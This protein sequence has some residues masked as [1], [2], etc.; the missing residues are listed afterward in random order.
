MH[1]ADAIIIGGGVTGLSTAYHLAKRGFGR[2][3]V[4]EKGPVGDGSSSRAGGIIT[5]LL[6]SEAGVLARKK[7]LELYRA[8]SE[9]LDGYT[10]QA[11][12][13]LN[14]FD[15]PSWP[16]RERLLPLYDRLGA[17]YE[18]MSAAEMR[19]RWPALVIRDEDC[20]L[21]DPLG[22]YSEPHEYVPALAR[23]VRELGVEIREQTAVSELIVRGGRA[24]GV[25]TAD[26]VIEAGAVV[27]TVYAWTHVVLGPHGV[28]LPVKSFVHQRYVTVPLAAPV[29][30]P[31]IN[32]NPLGGYIRP[33]HGG[34][35]LAGIE[36]AE[37]EEFRVTDRHFHM[38]ALQAPDGIDQVLHERFAGFVPALASAPWE[39]EKVGLLTFAMDGEPIVGPIAAVPGL[40]V[41]VAFHS[42]GFAYNPVSGMLLAEFVADGR[43]SIDISAFAPERFDPVE[44]EAYLADTVA[45]RDVVRRRH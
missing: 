5:G 7:A 17:P 41:G 22:G 28:R 6:W 19:Q 42:G 30:I 39:S 16:D 29:D 26:G 14:M 33:A 25:R 2:I 38:S 8:L 43:T 1:T 36:T 10:F 9:E 24:A 31:A 27:S 40:F 15:P 45:Q 11:V 13:C 44:V 34:R 32:A 20:G 23:R 35:L 21:F 4:L 37:R 3:V 18:I 12:G